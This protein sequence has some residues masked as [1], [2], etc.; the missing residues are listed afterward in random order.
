MSKIENYRRE[1]YCWKDKDYRD[2]IG[3]ILT[4]LEPFHEKKK[5]KIIEEL[6]EFN[7]V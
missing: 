5:T 2:F 6:D 4:H 7:I 3:F 1:Y